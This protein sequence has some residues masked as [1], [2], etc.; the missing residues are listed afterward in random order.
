MFQKRLFLYF[1]RL[2]NSKNIKKS[3]K[4]TR[5]IFSSV[6]VISLQIVNPYQYDR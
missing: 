1:K 6:I 4:I 5:L 3:L 2:T